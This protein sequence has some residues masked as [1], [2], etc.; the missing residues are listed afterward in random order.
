MVFLLC[1]ALLLRSRQPG[2]FWR[3]ILAAERG[4]VEVVRELLTR[5]DVE[6][7]HINNLGWTALLEAVILGEGKVAHQQIVQLLVDH[8][9]DVQIAD[10]DGVTPL[11]HARRRGFT[12]IANTLAK[13]GA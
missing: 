2:P 13:A 1:Q 4:H 10:K 5:S 12:E 3:Q 6:V 7:N 9:A 8:G 11:Q